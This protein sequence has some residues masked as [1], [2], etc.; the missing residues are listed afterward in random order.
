MAKS[1]PTLL[2]VIVISL[3]FHDMT[4]LYKKETKKS[5]RFF[6]LTFIKINAHLLSKVK[7]TINQEE[8]QKEF[9]EGFPLF[10]LCSS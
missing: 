8:K 9:F 1:L 5:K 4:Y 2:I 7:I 10:F 6:V 3:F